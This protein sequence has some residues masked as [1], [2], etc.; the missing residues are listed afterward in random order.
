[1]KNQI[2]TKDIKE[3]K[4]MVD[5]CRTKNVK[6]HYQL[7]GYLDRKKKLLPEVSINQKQVITNKENG[8]TV[9]VQ[10]IIIM[11]ITMKE[12]ICSVSN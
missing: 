12:A 11:V 9:K 8:E 4:N 5:I 3:P 6:I 10:N 2:D 1:M 7:R